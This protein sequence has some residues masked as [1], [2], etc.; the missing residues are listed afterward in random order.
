MMP[1]A[2]LRSFANAGKLC[3]E[4]DSFECALDESDDKKGVERIQ[5]TPA[6]LAN[7]RSVSL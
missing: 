1:D 4:T 3:G 5:R 2:H 6:G 7:K